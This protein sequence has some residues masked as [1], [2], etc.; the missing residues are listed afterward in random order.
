MLVMME[1]ICLYSFMQ[2]TNLNE[3]VVEKKRRD[4][5]TSK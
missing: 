5:S 2:F 3:I 1:N 4:R